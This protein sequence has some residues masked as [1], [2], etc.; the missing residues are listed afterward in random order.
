MEKTLCLEA[1]HNPDVHFADFSKCTERLCLIV[2][3]RATHHGCV[4][5]RT[6]A[7]I[8]LPVLRCSINLL[9]SRKIVHLIQ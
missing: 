1:D 4:P 7:V 9:T 8:K 3:S 6:R 5:G 2:Q